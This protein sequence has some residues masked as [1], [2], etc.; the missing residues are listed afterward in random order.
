MLKPGVAR[1]AGVI[2]VAVAAMTFMAWNPE[3]RVAPAGEWPN[4][5]P[6]AKADPALAQRMY[7]AAPLAVPALRAIEPPAVSRQLLEATRIGAP[8][9]AND[10]AASDP[11]PAMPLPERV[12]AA[13][14]SPFPPPAQTAPQ[15]EGASDDEASKEPPPQ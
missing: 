5:A 2:A 10:D 13:S 1:V 8:E 4:A 7:E 15:A 12:D 14:A 6:I 9:A 3:R 11:A